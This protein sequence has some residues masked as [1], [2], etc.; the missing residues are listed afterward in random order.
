MSRGEPVVPI[1][2]QR[3]R[4]VLVVVLAMA[5]IV[6]MAALVVTYVAFPGRG[7]QVPGAPWLGDALAQGAERLGLEENEEIGR[8]RVDSSR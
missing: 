3:N 5:L 1:G 8:Q 2:L 6:A 4:F 7:R